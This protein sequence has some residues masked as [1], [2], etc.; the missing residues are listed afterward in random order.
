M[1]DVLWWMGATV[2]RRLK[3]RAAPAG[4]LLF[5]MT[6]VV[7]CELAAIEVGTGTLKQ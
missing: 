3:L 1:I 7:V 5:V 6:K 2:P 4:Q